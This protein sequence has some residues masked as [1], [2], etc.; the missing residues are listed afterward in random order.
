MKALKTQ[1]HFLFFIKITHKPLPCF[2][3]TI[4][5]TLA[6]SFSLVQWRNPLQMCFSNTLE[7]LS[8]KVPTPHWHVCPSTTPSSRSFP[9]LLFQFC[10]VRV[11][12]PSVSCCCA[13]AF[14]TD[15]F[16]CCHKAVLTRATE[17][18]KNRAE[19]QNRQQW[20]TER[21]QERVAQWD[22]CCCDAMEMLVGSTQALHDNFELKTY[23]H[24][25]VDVYRLFELI[26]EYNL[27]GYGLTSSRCSS[28]SSVYPP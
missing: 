16:L 14:L 25:M 8:H 2:I 13:T 15:Q 9:L 18:E 21:R 17:R 26:V 22:H 3:W 5:V 11:G 10:C 19:G 6:S 4:V 23:K 1:F 12:A 20:Q 27:K 7:C 24:N 28:G